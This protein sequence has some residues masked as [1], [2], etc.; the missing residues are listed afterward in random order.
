LQKHNNII[1]NII[2]A[3]LES[4]VILQRHQSKEMA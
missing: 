2:Y 1:I 4:H 3:K